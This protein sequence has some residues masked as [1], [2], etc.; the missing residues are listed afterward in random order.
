MNDP[1][2]LLA[3]AGL[4]LALVL[5]PPLSRWALTRLVGGAIGRRALARQT[6]RITLAPAGDDAWREPATPRALAASLLGLG[7]E[8]AGTFR[9][10]EMPGTVVR[11]LVHEQDA[12]VAAVYE[13]PRA[14]HW[15][16]VVTY[17]ADCTASCF[18]TAPATG[19]DARPGFQRVNAPGTGAAELVARARAERPARARRPVPAARAAAEFAAA[20]AD[21]MAWR[22][23][24]GVSAREVAEVAARMRDRRVA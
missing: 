23:Q 20:Y 15:F 4:A 14:G 16:D 10:S 9:V 17:H 8:D 1:Q 3:L 11:L 2:A 21:D 22:K 12:F 5:L 6:D 7:F 24:R 13:H 18:S 19:L